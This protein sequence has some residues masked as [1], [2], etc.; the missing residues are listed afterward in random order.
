MARMVSGLTSC[1]QAYRPLVCPYCCQSDRFK[2]ENVMSLLSLKPS[3][4]SYGFEGRPDSSVGL[5]LLPHGQGRVPTHAQCCGHWALPAGTQKA[6]AHTELSSAR[7]PPLPRPNTC[8]SRFGYSAISF[9]T[10]SP[11]CPV[12]V[13]CLPCAPESSTVYVWAVDTCSFIP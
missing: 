1:L 2:I 8:S 7:H 12:R 13:R 9:S 10:V 5:A 4:G 3:T 11:T 6:F